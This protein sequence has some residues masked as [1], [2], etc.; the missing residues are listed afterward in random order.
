MQ[1]WSLW[2]ALPLLALLAAPA[3]HAGLF[4]DDEARKQIT[5]LRE[6]VTERLEKLDAASRSQLE[7]ANQLESLRA[8]LAK[9][10]GQIEVLTYENDAAQKR[11]RDFY[12]DLDSR[13]RK[14][15]SGPVA[16]DK[17]AEA[18][19]AKADPQAETHD[20]EA[21]LNFFK[22]GKYKEAQAAFEGFLKAYP[23]S[24]LAPSAQYWLGNTHYAAH[25]CKKAIEVQSAL[26]A[27]WADSPKVPD[28]LLS[29]ATCQQELGDGKAA[30][31]TLD[32]VIAQYPSSVAAEVARQ[33][34]KKK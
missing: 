4:D 14:L 30:H 1:R 9:L 20:Y 29:V 6:Q 3:A 17:P 21:A 32:V 27:K 22:A 5:A 31:K 7:L 12:I 18:A 8:D 28:A 25:D 26:V 11:Q 34:L 24:T 15:E 2:R 13:L 19:T 10:Q 16:A 23:A 33:R